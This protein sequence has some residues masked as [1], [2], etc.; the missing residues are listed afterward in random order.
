MRAEPRYGWA[1]V[2]SEVKEFRVRALNVVVLIVHHKRSLELYAESKG[3]LPRRH[4]G[5][6]M[7]PR[8]GNVSERKYRAVL[9]LLRSKSRWERPGPGW[10]R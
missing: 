6:D 8:D 2:H 9:M 5:H 1:L 3:V 4:A 7:E 10:F